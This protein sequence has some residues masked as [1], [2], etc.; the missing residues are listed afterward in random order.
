MHNS[1]RFTSDLWKFCFSSLL[2]QSAEK[3]RRVEE[4]EREIER[5]EDRIVKLEYAANDLQQYSRRSSLRIFGVTET[6]NETTDQIVCKIAAD[7]LRIALS[8]GDIDR[9]HRVGKPGGRHHRAIIVK[10]CSYRKR[11]EII[12]ARR[13]LK[14]TGITI[15]EDLTQHNAQLYARTYKHRKVLAAWTRDGMIIASIQASGGK[16]TSKVIRSDIDLENL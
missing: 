4:L 7:Q 5:K 12:Q 8:P 1:T 11:T 3:N 14:N 9:S 15:Q 13:S 6:P 2:S 16:S 10:F